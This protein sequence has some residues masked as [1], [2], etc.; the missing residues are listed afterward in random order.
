MGNILGENFDPPI[1]QQI[2]VR[3]KYFGDRT[4]GLE[5]GYIE[6]RNQLLY[7]NAPFVKLCSSVNIDDDIAKNKLGISTNYSGN[8]LAKEFILFSGTS[9]ESD[10][11][12][13]PIEFD[14]EGNPTRFET[15]VNNNL[16]A[17]LNNNKSILGNQAYGLGGLDFGQVPQ[18][19]ITDLRVNHKNRGSLREAQINLKAYNQKQ[20][21]IIDVLYLRLGYTVLL[22]WGHSVYIDNGEN[23]QNF[24]STLSNS[25]LD[26]KIKDYY[27]AL[28]LARTNTL[29]KNGNYDVMVGKVTNFNWSFNPDGSYDINITVISIGDVIESLKVDV[30]YGTSTTIE[31]DK[32]TLAKNKARQAIESFTISTSPLPTGA[33]IGGGYSAPGNTTTTFQT[34][35]RIIKEDDTYLT[36]KDY[37]NRIGGTKHTAADDPTHIVKYGNYNRALEDAEEY[38]YDLLSNYITGVTSIT[39]NSNFTSTDLSSLTSE[40]GKKLKSIKELL[41]T[42]RSSNNIVT[43]SNGKVRYHQGFSGFDATDFVMVKF[44]NQPSPTGTGTIEVRKSYIRL[45]YLLQILEKDIIFKYKNG[46]N[47]QPCLTFDTGDNNYFYVNQY[48]YGADLNKAISRKVGF[49]F[50]AKTYNLLDIPNSPLEK[51]YGV[52][53]LMNVLINIDFL[54]DILVKGFTSEK[55]VIL[56]DF[57]DEICKAIN[58]SFG[59][60]NKIE[61]VI[62]E[63]EN[64]VYL[65]DSTPLLLN[66]DKKNKL[67]RNKLTSL[68]QVYGFD[69]LNTGTYDV[70][71]SFIKNFSIKSE[72]TNNLATQLSIGAQAIGRVTSQNATAFQSWNQGILD[73]ISPQKTDPK[74][75]DPTTPDTTNYTLLVVEIEE[76]LKKYQSKD[77]TED[78]ILSLIKHNKTTQ[79]LFSSRLAQSSKFPTAGGEAFIPINLNL[80]MHGL[81]GMKIY[82]TFDINSKFLPTNYDKKL[83]FLIKKINH[84]ISLKGWE[85]TIETLVVPKTVDANNS[86]VDITKIAKSINPFNS[87]PLAGGNIPLTYPFTGATP[88]A[89]QL[90]AFISTV[91]IQEKFKYGSIGELSSGGDITQNLVDLAIAV[92]TELKNQISKDA[93]LL[94]LWNNGVVVI[95]AGNDVFH[96]ID[97]NVSPNSRHKTGNALDIDVLDPTLRPEVDKILSAIAVANSNISYINEYDMPSSTGGNTG[98]NNSHFHLSYGPSVGYAA[99]EELRTKIRI[100]NGEF[101]PIYVT[102]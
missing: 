72:I 21:E 76:L 38:Y 83:K 32:R 39:P 56:Y 30:L 26:G 91:G 52:G 68:F 6:K 25:F 99:N 90:R 59:G 82:Q 33:A 55:G 2:E 31:A 88:N 69:P 14:D 18:P 23:L 28:A 24:N 63:V 53:Y 95:T 29:A 46:T 97:P 20:F 67:L 11:F 35:Y 61:P 44:A 5:E 12:Q 64:R 81:S 16:R 58:N 75:E 57:L 85:T 60:V 73:R 37:L 9:T 19:G 102:F 71:G 27:T 89:D 34:G 92:L 62:D 96:Q 65:I 93:N 51:E 17:G 40:L 4:G 50:N 87:V 47:L 15:R 74:G 77:V 98:I 84:D 66:E 8:K 22:E 80:T 54:S 100:G 94:N 43:S 78:Q 7:A 42:G 36:V 10:P 49:N 101:V 1:R 45:G 3:Q 79:K 41:D 70:D 86:P 48:S 13:A